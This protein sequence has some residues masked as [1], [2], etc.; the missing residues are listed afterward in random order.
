MFTAGRRLDFA[1]G[2]RWPRLQTERSRSVGELAGRPVF[3]REAVQLDTAALDE[4]GSIDEIHNDVR[5][6]TRRQLQ[7][8]GKNAGGFLQRSRIR[9]VD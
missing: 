8:F 9:H 4:H 5:L 7:L 2:H 1:S 6:W 3:D